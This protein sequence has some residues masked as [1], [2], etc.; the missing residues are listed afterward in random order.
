M[1]VGMLGMH[2]HY[3]P[4]KL[5]NKADLLIAIGMRFD[6]RVTSKLSVYAKQARII[7]IDIDESEVNKNV[8]TNVSIVA[9]AKDVLRTLNPLVNK[10]AHA[11]W[12]NNFVEHSKI[13]YDRVIKHEVAHSGNEITM[14][15]IVSELSDQVKGEAILVA[16]VGQNQMKSARYFNFTKPRTFITSGGAGTMGF[17]LPAVIGAK[18]AKPNMNAIAIIGDG[19]FQMTIQELGTIS[20]E[21]LPVKIIIMHNGYLGMVRQWQELFFSKRYSFT[22]LHNPDFLKIAEG[23]GI[24]GKR[25][26]K[27]EDVKLAVSE[28]VS[29]KGPYILEFMVKPEENVF[30]MVPTN[31]SLDD[32]RLE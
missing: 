7:H 25:V 2:G 30:P 14:A 13:E 28:M 17:A 1:Y 26:A 8:K 10:A 4:N 3:G 12:M 19:A 5:T 22:P 16:D 18:F 31:S 24:Q 21:K 27:R 9:D 32:I 15:E 23:Y 11:D 20:Q 29:A 6:D